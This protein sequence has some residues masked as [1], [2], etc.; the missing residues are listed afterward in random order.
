M[1]YPGGKGAAGVYQRIINLMPPHDVYIEPFLGGGNILERKKPAAVSIAIDADVGLI[2][3]WKAKG[4]RSTNFICGDAISYLRNYKFC[5]KELI[6]CD[7][8][9]VLSSRKGGRIYKHE[10][11][12]DQHLQLV[13][14][15]VTIPAAIMI[16]GYRNSIY[17]GLLKSWTRLDYSVIL[18]S[19]DTAI[20][21]LWFNFEPPQYR[22]DYKYIGENFRER[23]RIKRKQA[24]WKSRLEKLPVAER[25]AMMQ[26]LMDLAAS[27]I[28]M[29]PATSSILTISD[30]LVDP[31]AIS[32][33]VGLHRQK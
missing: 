17:D 22:H 28:A 8:P 6:Y 13:S 32:D 10:L 26:I 24:R 4:W 33:D 7:P 25:V 23:E 21:S 19:G 2:A 30:R 5:G 16:S 15:L 29:L 14:L 1:R 20:E 12:E 9:Y 18:R 3:T 31:I 27:E 11:T